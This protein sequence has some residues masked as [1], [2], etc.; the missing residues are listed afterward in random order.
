MDFKII[1]LNLNY[2][3]IVDFKI[4]RVTVYAIIEHL[5]GLQLSGLFFNI[6]SRSLQC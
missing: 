2:R 6:A 1:L 4:G 5:W 3:Y